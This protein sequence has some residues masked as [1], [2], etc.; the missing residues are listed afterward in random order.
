MTNAPVK[1][2]FSDLTDRKD[3]LTYQKYKRVPFTGVAE[4]YYPNGQI[5]CRA[6]YQN[7]KLEGSR[8]YFHENGKLYYEHHYKNDKREDGTYEYFDSKGRLNHK[9]H[10]KDGELHGLWEWFYSNGQLHFSQNWKHG[11]EHGPYLDFYDDGRINHTG[12]YKN[13]KK[14]GVFDFYDLDTGEYR[15]A[16]SKF[17]KDGVEIT[18][19]NPEDWITDDIFNQNHDYDDVFAY[20]VKTMKPYTGLVEYF[21][22]PGSLFQRTNF[23]NGRLHGLE[24]MFHKNGQICERRNYKKGE[25]HGS[26]EKFNEKL[27]I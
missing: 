9:E 14:H 24:E 27:R 21:F 8:C 5:A 16:I 12:N 23:K 4:N 15:L 7:G 19:I 18:W 20:S 26:F 11:N 2:N 13:G 10:Y 22:E 3:G 6:N 1:I 17:Y 25:R